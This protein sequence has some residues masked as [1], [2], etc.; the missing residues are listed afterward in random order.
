VNDQQAGRLLRAYRHRRGWRQADLAERAGLSQSTE[1][2]AELGH[3]ETLTLGAIRRLFRA[4][5][6]LVELNVRGRGGD[7]DRLLDAVHADLVRAI[8]EYLAARGWTCWFEVTYSRYGE[9]GSID[10]LA[11]RGDAV[12]V[13]EVKSEL[14][15]LEETLRKL[16]EKTRLAATIVFERTGKRP[17][18][19]GRLL[20]LPNSTAAR[21][22]VARH[23][24]V[25]GRTFPSRSL[26]LRA[27]LRDPSGPFSGIHFVRNTDRDGTTRRRT[28]KR[29]RIRRDSVRPTAPAGRPNA[30]RA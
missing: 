11:I 14:T 10:V 13:V 1:S 3:F 20:V 22:R 8:G 4:C 26:E 27:W 24:A 19:V 7:G 5:D 29:C 30:T 21:D 12:L 25:L 6:A 2:A 28:N 17:R 16:D 9:R 15:S 23:A 18:V